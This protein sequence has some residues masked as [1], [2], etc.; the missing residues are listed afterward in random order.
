M[1]NQ[2]FDNG[3]DEQ[4]YTNKFVLENVLDTEGFQHDAK[5][6]NCGKDAVERNFDECLGGSINP[7][8]TLDCPH[9]NYHECSQEFCHTCEAESAMSGDDM[10]DCFEIVQHADLLLD[11]LIETLT[12][13][14]HVNAV[15]LTSLKLMLVSHEKATRL[16]DDIFVPTNART[17]HYIQRKLLD[18]KFSRNLDLKIKQAEASFA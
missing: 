12:E 10:S 1:K 2:F 17:F 11:H 3:N 8:H 9:C 14:K 7:V 15:E 16:F 18:A 13:K 5:C 6:P 4:A